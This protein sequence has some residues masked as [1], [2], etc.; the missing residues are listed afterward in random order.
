MADPGILLCASSDPVRDIMIKFC[1]IRVSVI[2]L[3]AS[4]DPVPRHHDQSWRSRLQQWRIYF[5]PHRFI[6]Q[7]NLYIFYFFNIS[8]VIFCNSST[9]YTTTIFINQSY[10]EDSPRQCQN[11]SHA[12]SIMYYQLIASIYPWQLQM[13]MAPY[14]IMTTFSSSFVI[15]KIPQ[16]SEK[17]PSGP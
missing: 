7:V 17:I 10:C 6:Q 9:P 13:Y 8:V 16:S 3:C 5:L 14:D 4:S 11:I 12:V 1:S 15:K 2:L